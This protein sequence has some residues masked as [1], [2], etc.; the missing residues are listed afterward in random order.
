MYS[1]VHEFSCLCHGAV[2]RS[3]LPHCAPRRD[4]WRWWPPH[5][6][7]FMKSKV[8]SCPPLSSG[9]EFLC[10]DNNSDSLRVSVEGMNTR[11]WNNFTFQLRERLTNFLRSPPFHLIF[12]TTQ[13]VPHILGVVVAGAPC[14]VAAGPPLPFAEALTTLLTMVESP[15]LEHIVCFSWYFQLLL[16]FPR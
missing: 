3:F 16:P 14:T 4:L 12:S 10:M 11:A 1:A 7:W 9:A 8:E 2:I 5:L 6:V 13:A 15:E